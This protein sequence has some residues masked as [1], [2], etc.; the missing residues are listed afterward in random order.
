MQGIPFLALIVLCAVISSLYCCCKK[1]FFKDMF[2][3]RGF[4]DKRHVLQPTYKDEFHKMK[5]RGLV[6]YDIRGNAD[7]FEVA[8]ELD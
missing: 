3:V 6:T 5:N 7:Y 8:M 1:G 4:E 2:D